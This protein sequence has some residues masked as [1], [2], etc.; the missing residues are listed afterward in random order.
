[1]LTHWPRACDQVAAD[2]RDLELRGRLEQEAKRWQD[3]S[4]HDKRDRVLPAGLRLAEGLALCTRWG[5][6]LPAEVTSFVAASRHAARRNRRR[7][8]ATM[9][10]A[11]VALPLVAALVWAGLVMWGVHT[12]E[13]EMEFVAIPAGCFQMGSPDTEAERYPNEGPVHEA[14]PKAFELGKFEVTQAEWRRV[15]IHN[16]D[17]SQY[18]GDR[19][20]VESVSWNEA[21]TFI[22]LMNFFGR[23]HYR[24]PSEAEWEYAARGGTTTARYWGERAENGCAYENMADQSL[25]KASPDSVVANCD[26]GQITTAP[27]GT[28]KPNP[29]GLYDILGN[30]GEWVEDCYVGNYEEAPK[31]GTAFATE[32][33]SSR[34]VRGGSWS[35]VP[36]DLRAAFRDVVTPDYRSGDVGFRLAR[37]VAP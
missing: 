25:K 19:R 23:H 5:A 18:K 20:P 22:W 32:D 2:A 11:V 16:R 12:V 27:V 10:G 9:V 35:Y 7:R 15:M 24:L 29:W 36:R 30:V 28:F 8:I 26:D 4:R 34:V 6:A 13:A 17:P 31:D 33:C 3:A 21:Q 1:L 37:T 14:C